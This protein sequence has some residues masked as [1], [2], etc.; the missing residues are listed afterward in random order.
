M[1]CPSL[2]CMVSKINNHS[3][4]VP[5][6]NLVMRV[7]TQRAHLLKIAT[8]ASVSV[9]LTL[10]GL[11][12]WAWILSGSVSLLASLV[13]SVMDAAASL[14][15]LF[16]VRVALKPADAEHRFGHGK[17][18][19]LAA[20][21]QAAFITGSAAFLILESIDR[22]IHPQPIQATSLG[23]WVMVFSMALTLALISLQRW[24]I[25]RTK[26]QAIA[27]DSLHYI[28]D[29]LSNI[30]VIIALILVS[31]GVDGADVYLALLLVVWIL[32]S[33][34][35]IAKDAINELMDRELPEK[36]Q[37][38]I[39]VKV[40]SVVGVRGF[41]DL[42]TR[43]SGGRYFVQLHIEL[44]DALILYAAHKIADEVER[45]ILAILPE[46]SEVLVH[47]DPVSVVSKGG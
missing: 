3:S 18:E 15:N 4:F 23:L 31:L 45:S 20:L 41:H 7:K 16:A 9:A 25:R 12:A 17:A 34:W 43:T 40:R 28:S 1:Q 2:S 22:L 30:V 33:A 24:V 35:D 26:S 21:A 29:L 46:Y 19:A 27:A 13:D 39:I 10:I 32:K 8:Y 5:W 44:D 6:G 47:Q 37:Q 38:Q 11:K 36:Y 14:I 42:K